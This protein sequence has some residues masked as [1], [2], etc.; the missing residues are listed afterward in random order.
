MTQQQRKDAQ[1]AV[2]KY[3]QNP[4]CSRAQFF[5]RYQGVYRQCIVRVFNEKVFNVVSYD[6]N[7]TE[8]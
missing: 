3:L 1:K 7:L 5:S 4:T 8:K 6:E 2:S